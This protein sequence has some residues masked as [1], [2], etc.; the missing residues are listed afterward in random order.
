MHSMTTNR[1]EQAGA[2]LT[3]DLGAICANYRLLRERVGAGACAAVIKAD[4]YG[5]GAARVAPALAAAGCRHF[6][7]A[8]LDEAIALRP[9][10]SESAALYVL[11][12]S[13]PA[14]EAEFLAH[15]LI[16]VLNSLLQV[17]AW[18]ALARAKG[19]ALPAILQVDTG[20]SRLGLSAR[21][22]ATVAE[23]PHCLDGI[24]LRYVMSHLA[25]AEQQEHPMNAQQ[26]TAF[27]QALQRLPRAPAS[28]A[29]SS[30]IFL[31]PDYHFDLARPGA[32]LYGVA[33]VAGAPNPMCQVVRLQ[34]KVIQVRRIEAGTA[35]G[36][37]ARYRAP[38]AR[39]IAT[40]SVGYADGYLRSLSDRAVAWFGDT[41]LPLVGI[42]SMDTISL[43]VSDLPEDA[44]QPGS[45]VD[46]I[47]ERQT[48]DAL[49]QAAGTIGYEILTSLGGRYARDYVGA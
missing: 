6:F 37:S 46:L 2:L 11:H 41:A 19:E 31:G 14:V 16:P 39:R 40:V 47:N 38:S 5:L 7:V 10:L 24:E 4:G 33:P 48:V 3:I 12:G 13:P 26:L 32:A 21:E 15:R 42:V 8:H 18:A 28:F 43:D 9:H 29:N 17:D 45:L 1:A 36:Y 35:V 23:D 20:M 30:G 34:G 49:A 25:C 22:L 27:R 44:L